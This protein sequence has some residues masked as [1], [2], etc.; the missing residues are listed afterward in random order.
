MTV[1]NSNKQRYLIAYDITH[2]KR[3]RRVARILEKHAM[4]LQKSVFQFYGTDD[5]LMS[6]VNELHEV[7]D[8]EEDLVQAWNVKQE[9]RAAKAVLGKQPEHSPVAAV[10]SA[11]QTCFVSQDK[12]GITQ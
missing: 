1:D 10:L 5:E 8:H 9:N 2:P 11:T 6:V 7:I 12:K 3:L 4:R